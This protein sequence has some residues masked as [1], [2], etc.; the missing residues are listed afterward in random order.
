MKN[1]KNIII[2]A[3]LIVI[4]L[5]AVGYSAFATQ[6]T[7]NG[8]AEITGIW[9]VK[10]TYIEAQEIS[11]GCDPGEP[12][13]TNTTATF[14]AKLVKPGDIIIYEITIQN[15]GTIDATLDKALFEADDVNGS[16]AIRYTVTEPDKTL[17][18]GEETTVTIAIVYPTTTSEVPS[19]KTKT[20]TGVIE[21]VQE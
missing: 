20:I 12:Q 1:T 8:I 19:V 15:A 3:L 18:A 6:L 7:L 13:Y 14:N 11:I 10:I 17:K 9:D 4:L 2:G 16:P 21:Y 5:M